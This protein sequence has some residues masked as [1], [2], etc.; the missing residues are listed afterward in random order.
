[1]DLQTESILTIIDTTKSVLTGASMNLSAAKQ[2]LVRALGA[3]ER[4]DATFEKIGVLADKMAA[5]EAALEEALIAKA[6]ATMVETKI[7]EAK[8][9]SEESERPSEYDKKY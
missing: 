5:R 6:K 8:A 9:A 1:M 3:F 7:A 2:A 4:S